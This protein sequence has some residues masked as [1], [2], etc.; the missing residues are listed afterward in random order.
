MK[1][2]DI[3]VEELPKRGGWPKGAEYCHLT[4]YNRH[5]LTITFY[6]NKIGAGNNPII[7]MKD[8]V[9]SGIGSLGD[10][11]CECTAA[12]EQYEAA[13]AAKNDGWIE[14]G[15]GECPVP[16]GTPVDVKHRDGG[17][18]VNK[19][20]LGDSNVRWSHVG[21]SGDIIAYRLHRPQEAVQDK[22]DDEADLNE[23][24]GQVPAPVWNG[25][26]LPPVGCECEMQNDRGEWISVDI[27]AQ[28]DGFSFGWNYDYRM[29]YF[30]DKSAEFR[31]IRTEAD[32][33]RDERASAIDGFISG[34]RG[35]E[36]GSNKELAYALAD[37]LAL[38]DKL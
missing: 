31:P 7:S 16:I 24:I 37:Y 30:S 36:T 14:W 12:Y 21:S 1:L 2:I 9:F 19:P 8:I 17:V 13:L 25:E 4:Q 5:C 35:Q 22:A 27:I 38:I 11:L 10:R 26:G 18:Y 34:F 3:L 33:K 23:C 32:R 28:N 6:Q 15:G 20:A 29:V